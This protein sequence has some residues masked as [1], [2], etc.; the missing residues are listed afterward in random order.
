MSRRLAWMA[1]GS[2]ASSKAAELRGTR[3]LDRIGW[4]FTFTMAAYN[5][6]RMRRL[7]ATA[8]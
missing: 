1:S 2:T 4:R 6:I 8:G 7:L 3:G 5:L